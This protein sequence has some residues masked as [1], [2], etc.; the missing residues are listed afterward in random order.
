M[1]KVIGNIKKQAAAKYTDRNESSSIH[2]TF[3]LLSSSLHRAARDGDIAT[4][5][6]AID[7]GK[8]INS[9]GMLFAAIKYS[10]RPHSIKDVV[11]LILEQEGTNPNQKDYDN[12]TAL[13]WAVE[14]WHQETVKVLIEYG[15]DPYMADNKL[16]TPFHIAA[17]HADMRTM[18]MLLSKASNK[19]TLLNAD[20]KSPLC[21]LAE[22][23]LYIVPPKYV[24]P[25]C[26]N[27]P[28]VV[29]KLLEFFDFD[30]LDY[31]H[32]LSLA[33]SRNLLPPVK[34]LLNYDMTKFEDSAKNYVEENLIGALASCNFSKPNWPEITSAFLERGG[35]LGLAM[36]NSR[37]L[38]AKLNNIDDVNKIISASDGAEKQ[39]LC[40]LTL[41]EH[42]IDRTDI[43]E[44]IL[45]EIHNLFPSIKETNQDFIDQCLERINHLPSAKIHED[46]S[47]TLRLSAFNENDESAE[48]TGDDVESIVLNL[49]ELGKD[50]Q[51]STENP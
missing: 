34:Y 15:A 36:K 3:L 40:A 33:T 11:K 32:A 1:Q 26:V 23:D 48:Q 42:L 50:M 51:G 7:S 38:K 29:Q 8:K 35:K 5:Q 41:L 12:R 22:N 28:E 14:K 43:K 9:Y 27:P 21:L 24:N 10:K 16:E 37:N 13:F 6:K 31:V 18:E 17:R 19:S 47:T 46:L 45:K 49:E 20:N 30:P 4:L 2:E 25:A 44:H 39:I